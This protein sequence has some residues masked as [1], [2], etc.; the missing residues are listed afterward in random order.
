MP[1]GSLTGRPPS[2]NPRVQNVAFRL[3]A[4]ERAQLDEAA[5]LLGC[6]KTRVVTDG[7]ALV[8]A[9]AMSIKARMEEGK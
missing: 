5:E 1:R 9:R 3:A 7:I 6:T 2:T 8:H 4:E